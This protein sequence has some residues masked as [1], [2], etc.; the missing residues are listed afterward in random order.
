LFI[1]TQRERLHEGDEDVADLIDLEVV[2]VADDV[3]NVIVG[4]E[5][6][7]RGVV[8]D[9]LTKNTQSL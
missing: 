4:K 5:I 1:E 6:V 8:L 2:R 9:A 7:E 3:V